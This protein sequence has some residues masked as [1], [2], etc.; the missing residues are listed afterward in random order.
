MPSSA[1]ATGMVDWVLQVEQMP[2]RLLDYRRLDGKLRLPPEQAPHSGP[3]EQ[4]NALQEVLAFLRTR[5]GR[6]FSYY[7]RATTL[8]RIAR[9]MQV[10]GVATLPSYLDFLRT[11]TGEATALLQDL[12]I[13]VTN[14][15]RDADTFAALQTQLPQLFH[16]KGADDTLRVW[17]PACATG[18]EAYSIAI[19]LCEHARMLQ[20]PPRL[21][22]FASDFDEDIIRVGREG[23]YPESISADVS[24]D[25]LKGFFRKEHRGYRVRR[26]IRESVL[27]A[28]HD[29]LKDSPFSR[30]DFISC[31]NLL[32]YLN[33]DA[34]QKLF[35][36]FHFALRP[37]GLLFLGLSETIDEDKA[38]F[39]T[40]DKTN[41][42]YRQRPGL[43]PGRPVP[44]GA[45]AL[46]RVLQARAQGEAAGHAGF[47]GAAGQRA[48]GLNG[49]EVDAARQE[50]R[51]VSW[52]EIHQ[53]V[54]EQRAAPSVLVNAEHEM[55]HLSESAG[56]YL[57]FSGGTPTNNVLRAVHPM[58]RLDL[59]AALYRAAQSQ[60]ETEVPQLPIEFDGEHKLV[61]LH[62]APT[63][64]LIQDVYLIVFK[65]ERAAAG[66][67]AGAATS[68]TD[69][70]A[71]EFERELERLKAHLRDTVQQYEGSAEELK[72]SNEE[73]Q[74][75]NEELR[76]ATEE[77]ETS[78]EELQSINEELTTVNHE[79]KERVDDL[80]HANSD[81]HN[82]MAATAIV[83]VFVDRELS[84]MRYTPSAVP[85]FRLIPTDIGRPL[86]DLSH[87]F[88]YPELLEDAQHVLEQLEPVQRE[89]S[90]GAHWYL[91][92]VLPYRN[93]DDRIGGVVFTFLDIT[94]RRQAEDSLRSSEER[95]RAIVSQAWAGVAYTDLT[96]RIAMANRR[97]A[98]IVGVG[99]HE[100]AGRLIEDF[101]H[102][103]DP[104]REREYFNRLAGSGQPFE[105]EKRLLRGDRR[106]AWVKAAVT[107]ILDSRGYQRAA[108]AIMLDV[109]ETARAREELQLSE[110]RLRLV[111]ENAREYAIFSTDL[112]RH[113]TSWNHGAE[114]LLGYAESEILHQ[115]ADV[116]FT[117]EDRVG[118]A[119]EAEAA[120]A[121]R[122][123]RAADERWH[124]RKDGSRFWGSGV[125]MAMHGAHGAI[126][127][128]VKIFRDETA[129][130]AAAEALEQSRGELWEALA[131]NKRAREELEAAS[132]AKDHFLA[133][134]SH[135][136][137]TPLTPV[138]VAVQALGMRSDLPQ[139]ARDALEVIRR[140]VRIE[141]H[142]IDD[143]L[144]LTKIARGQ[145]QV[146][147]EAMD[148]HDAIRGAIEICEPDIRT[149][150]QQLK[151]A[152][153]AP[154]HGVS[155]DARRLQQVVWNVLKNAS[156]FTPRGGD[157]LVTS[158]NDGDRFRLTVA[159]SGIGIEPETLEVIFDA[160]T[161]GSPRISREYG[162]LGLGL[163][164]SK[165]TIDAHGGRMAAESAGTNRGTTVTIELPLG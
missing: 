20:S 148:V 68:A 116:I 131:E 19:L 117:P 24:E 33:E 94:A 129:A 34:Q 63:A 10:N 2:R 135:E 101:T 128:L 25:R 29:V 127:G 43:R 85:L 158:S 114:R 105:I 102:P 104:A 18:E 97:F 72:A 47:H 8:R 15:F 108:V 76:S 146:L 152:L 64:D 157:I 153:N 99:E 13:S 154:R 160:F 11:H 1:I 46:A 140:N 67:E 137:R 79:L 126:V 14:F 143:L 53:K 86:S 50:T 80:A 3:A 28:L 134:L 112:Q 93:T 111:V 52:S 110:E 17:V 149:K 35:D 163:A 115:P 21:Q 132:R 71:R 142:F 38:L 39:H 109:S 98:D 30:L 78:R 12:L 49:D 70:A 27:F 145:L 106:D 107:P 44:V 159:D 89:V 32:I 164:I 150:D 48:L 61:D 95:F 57:Q 45:S 59:R 4:E 56:R 65:R 73:L 118:G 124:M 84:I 69:S 147:R 26:E 36:I 37:E 7:K 54:I 51:A 130:R 23:L 141:A 120:Q 103:D 144:D 83:T 123:G 81:L 121:L 58:L 156:K 82:L 42:I 136:L 96:G 5:T 66:D 155:G 138:L 77:L 87:R 74:A 41:R 92:R 125:M 161:Q 22:I 9:R 62:V 31:R 100:V 16:G 162:G 133:V 151:V 75:M 60:A 6:D 55:L 119:P 40:V 139:Q 90:S 122:D 91:T 88:E 113:V 165:A